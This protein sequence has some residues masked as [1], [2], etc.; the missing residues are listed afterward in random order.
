ML[1]NSL[2]VM[3]R[4]RAVF[5]AKQVDILVIDCLDPALDV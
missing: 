3:E 1:V 5:G 4:Y 2:D